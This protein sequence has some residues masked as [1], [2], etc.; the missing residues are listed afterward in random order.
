MLIGYAWQGLYF[1]NYNHVY[2]VRAYTKTLRQ[3]KESQIL[4]M[5]R[6]SCSDAVLCS[7]A[8]CLCL[9]LWFFIF[10]FYVYLC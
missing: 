10:Y 5:I 2:L 9:S 4:Q 3:V 6:L 7:V 1:I 8:D